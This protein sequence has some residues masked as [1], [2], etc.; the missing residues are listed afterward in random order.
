MYLDLTRERIFPLL[1]ISCALLAAIGGFILL[2]TAQR[3]TEKSSA[4][5][6]RGRSNAMYWLLY[7]RHGRELSASAMHPSRESARSVPV[8]VYH[9]EG[10]G[11]TNMPLKNFIDQMEALKREGWSTITMEQF[12]AFMKGETPLPDR[13]FLLTFDDGRRDTYYLFDPVLGDMGF[14][15]VMYVITGFSI[16]DPGRKPPSFYLNE[17]ELH[18]MAQSGRWELES[19]GKDDHSIYRVQSTT[20]LSLEAQTVEGNFLSNTFWNQNAGRFET[21]EE[22]AARIRKDFADS[23]ETLER[24]F[25]REVLSFAFPFNDFGQMTVN[26]PGARET[27]ARVMPQVY[28]FGMYQT[29]PGNGDSFNYPD[30]DTYMIRR[31]EPHN[32]WKGEDLM[33]E[34]ER[35]EAK[36][37]PYTATDFA[38]DWRG[39]WGAVATGDILEVSALPDTTGASAFLN[40]SGW[41]RDYLYSAEAQWH[42]GD[43][44]ALLARNRDNQRYVACVFSESGVTVE[45]RDGA[46]QVEL[47]HARFPIARGA[48]S[49]AIGVTGQTAT[50]YLDGEAVASAVTSAPATGGI[51][52]QAWAEEKGLARSSITGVSVRT[53]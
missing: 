10:A 43:A 8:L 23:R 14:H 50:C 47:A 37:L 19:H 26:N 36:E 29:W 9:G 24:E 21:Q 18:Y 12:R 7:K 15:A 33:R 5:I 1:V 31:I 28:L 51:G 49:I 20:D 17:S 42:S 25:G 3:V 41:W 39:N 38:E 48:L 22:Y 32:D 46:R 52:V 30:K 11:A 4:S 45:E 16:P 53:Q 35:G 2:D 34:L 44:V 13:S 27:I 40:G 6:A